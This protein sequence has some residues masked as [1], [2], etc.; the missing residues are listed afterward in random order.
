M[1]LPEKYKDKLQT[2]LISLGAK[3]VIVEGYSR[4]YE[5]WTDGDYSHIRTEYISSKGETIIVRDRIK[6]TGLWAE[7]TL[8]GIFLSTLKE[9]LRN[10]K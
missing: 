2:I 7:E 4:L 10:E 9:S 3:E 6:G 1:K 8:Q 5:T